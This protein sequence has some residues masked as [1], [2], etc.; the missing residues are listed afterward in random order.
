MAHHEPIKRFETGID[1]PRQTEEDPEDTE[2]A[3]DP[4]VEAITSPFPVSLG[5][6]CTLQPFTSLSLPPFLSA[7][8]IWCL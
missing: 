1:L 5:C 7:H 3:S 6:R 4:S 2:S 8:V